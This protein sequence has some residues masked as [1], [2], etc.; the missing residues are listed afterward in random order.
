MFSH[1][2][3]VAIAARSRD[4]VIGVGGQLPW[5]C[6]ADLRW[7][8]S[9]TKGHAIIMG[10]KTCESLP[11][12]KPLP[13]RLNIVVT[14]QEDYYREGFEVAGSL[15]EAALIA[16]RKKPRSIPFI[17]GG[18][19]LYKQ[20]LPYCIEAY[21]SNIDVFVGAG[22]ADVAR[23]PAL[24]HSVI[25]KQIHLN[26]DRRGVLSATPCVVTHHVFSNPKS[27]LK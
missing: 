20:A 13:D 21:I 17:V 27:L 6:P 15:K 5:H 25:D 14:R 19:D 23:M 9:L 11:G 18:A 8:K 7:F 10:R 16:F 24:P 2:N 3:F 12:G 26:Y 1:G 4:D 22:G